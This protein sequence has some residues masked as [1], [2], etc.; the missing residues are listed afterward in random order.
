MRGELC[1]KT[2]LHIQNKLIL[3][4]PLR[5]NGIYYL[6]K[7][8]YVVHW[9]TPVIF[10]LDIALSVNVFPGSFVKRQLRANWRFQRFRI[11]DSRAVM[12]AIKRYHSLINRYTFPRSQERRPREQKQKQHI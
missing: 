3:H 10:R 6:Y 9:N 4:L 11:F 5:F 7:N 1:S 8:L 12:I 2:V